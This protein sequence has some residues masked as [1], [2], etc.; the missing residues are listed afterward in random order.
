M[1]GCVP[2]FTK[3]RFSAPFFHE[4]INWSAISLHVPPSEL[5]A[6]PAILA[7]TDGAALRRAAAG[8]RRAL[9]WSSIYGSCHLQP[10]EGGAADAFDTL[11]AVLAQPRV[12]FTLSDAHRAPRAP[13]QLPQLA[14]WLRAHGGAECVESLEPSKGGTR[15]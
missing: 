15:S 1:L 5:P 13:E 2:I 8:M 4:A 9:L 10:A 7:R 14:R 12:H 6:L 11:M 3:E